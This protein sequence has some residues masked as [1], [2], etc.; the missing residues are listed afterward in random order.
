MG[1]DLSSVVAG[2][3]GYKAADQYARDETF[4]QAQRDYM[5]ADMAERTA[6]APSRAKAQEFNDAKINSGMGLLPQQT[7]N[8]Q[9]ALDAQAA[10]QA[11]ASERRPGLQDTA[12][13]G[14]ATART[15]A[16]TADTNAQTAGLESAANYKFAPIRI[17]TALTNGI[18]DTNTARVH[19]MAAIGQALVGNDI[20][21]AK[22]IAHDL[23]DNTDLFPGLKGKRIGSL[24]SGADANGQ[25]VV[26]M[27]AEDGSTMGQIPFAAF[28]G[29]MRQTQSKPDLKEVKD[30]HSLV[31]VGRDG[32]AT[33]VYRN[34]GDPVAKAA[35]NQTSLQKNAAYIQKVYGLTEKEALAQAQTG[36]REDRFTTVN[37][38]MSKNQMYQSQTDPAKRAAMRKP[39]E[40][41]YDAVYKN[42]PQTASAQAPAA[43][44]ANVLK[45]FDGPGL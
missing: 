7:A 6:G 4:L 16:R 20:E 32:A 28:A 27:L 18:L 34:Q 25:K 1:F 37:R 2:Y 29:A 31:S 19:S 42:G 35:A 44:P 8:A 43:V 45:L 24:T 30:G 9:G 21:G 15:N 33:E 39:Y 11:F 41:E 14:D 26:N 38:Q 3:K 23:A 40:D 36:S 12:V 13:M 5:Q 17:R 10:D 22:S